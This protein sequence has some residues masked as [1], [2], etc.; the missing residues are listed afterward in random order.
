MNAD[1]TQE[2]S[3]STRRG[4][5]SISPAFLFLLIYV[6]ISVIARDFYAMPVTVALLI[7]SVWG[8][9]I[10]RGQG[11]SKRIETFSQGAANPDILYMIWIF[12]LAGAFASLA[13]G[14]GAVDATVALTFKF[15]PASFILP[16][17]FFAACL[18]SFAIGTSVGAVVALMPLTQEIALASGAPVPM[19]V[20]AT[21]GGAFFGDNLSFISDTT[22]AATR[23]QRCRM[24]DKFRA[25]FA[26]VMPAAL[27]ALVLYTVLGLDLDVAVPKLEGEWWLTLPYLVVIVTAV[28]GINVTLVLLSGIL[29]AI[30]LGLFLGVGPLACCH[31]LGDGIDSMGQLIIITMLAGGMLGIVKATGGIAFLLRV[32]TAHLR[33]RA[34]AK[35]CVAGLVSLVNLCTANNT[36]AILTVGDVARS[37]SQRFGISPQ[38]TAS[39]LDTCS[40]IVQCLIPYG[41]QSLLAS[42]LAGITPGSMWPYLYYPWILAATV[43]LSITF[44]LPRE[45]N[46]S[47]V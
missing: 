14:L 15:F 23:T 43:A 28:A 29:T 25:N 12:I 41:A 35:W 33:R 27:I 24:S 16:A 21:L 18:I 17:C 11:L 46:A 1:S 36:V 34:A 39:I 22:I 7:A 37:I 13:K 44:N 45:K 20:A 6:G 26:I 5:L 4:L 42:G 9:A 32:L 8:V 2:A 31:L 38:K 30:V 10:C 47:R 3:V 19:F 40:C